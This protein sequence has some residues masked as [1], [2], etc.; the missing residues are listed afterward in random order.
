[1]RPYILT[2][3]G[4]SLAVGIAQYIRDEAKWSKIPFVCVDPF[5][6]KS[7]LKGVDLINQTAVDFWSLSLRLEKS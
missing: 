5:L 3:A 6:S 2:G 1:M 7:P 4:I